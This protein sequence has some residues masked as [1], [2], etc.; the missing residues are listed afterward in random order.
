MKHDFQLTYSVRPNGDTELEEKAA[1]KARKLL[2][3]VDE[4][5]PLKK[6]ETTFI[7]E[8]KLS[9]RD[10]DDKRREAEK[11]IDKL[12]T[13]TLKDSGLFHDVLVY[14]SLMVDK[15]GKH[16]EFRV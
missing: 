7:G 10:L 11:I 3:E 16:I 15:L 6:I 13:D 1:K 4:W 8:I 5:S 2:K 9:N 12:I 14:A